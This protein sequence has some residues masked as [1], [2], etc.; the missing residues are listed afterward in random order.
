MY[1]IH[2]NRIIS[3]LPRCGRKRERCH[4]SYLSSKA[5][6]NIVA[7]DITATRPRY[8]VSSLLLSNVLYLVDDFLAQSVRH[9]VRF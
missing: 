2:I 7:F 6:S 8:Y 5:T 9:F 1:I 3:S 4:L